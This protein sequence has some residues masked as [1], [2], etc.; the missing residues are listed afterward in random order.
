MQYA[1]LAIGSCVPAEDFV[2]RVAESCTSG[3]T[4]AYHRRC[5]TPC[6]SPCDASPA[7]GAAEQ[8]LCRLIG[9]GVGSGA[10]GL[11][12]GGRVGGTSGAPQ[13]SGESC[14]AAAK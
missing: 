7:P 12:Y 13:P 6:I 2:G 10:V 4:L 3:A 8:A 9:L 14:A 11:S 1:A 5:N